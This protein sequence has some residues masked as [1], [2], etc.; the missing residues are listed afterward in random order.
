MKT[1]KNKYFIMEDKG[2]NSFYIFVKHGKTGIK[3][4]DGLKIKTGTGKNNTRRKYNNV[5]VKLDQIR[6]T[7]KIFS[8]I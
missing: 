8:F 7:T 2:R 3:Y 1:N 6:K 4:A 5:L